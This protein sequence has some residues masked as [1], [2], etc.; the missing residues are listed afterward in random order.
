MPLGRAVVSVASIFLGVSAAW[1]QQSQVQLQSK[2]MP[3]PPL[4]QGIVVDAKGKTVGRLLNGVVVR[5]VNGTPV[6]IPVDSNGFQGGGLDNAVF[7]F[8]SADCTGTKYMDAGSILTTG[9]IITAPPSVPVPTL[10]FPAG[11]PTLRTI[12]SLTEGGPCVPVP[13]MA[14]MV[15]VTQSADVSSWG[16][17]PPF[18]VK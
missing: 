13:P 3:E 9:S 12:A 15:G 6:A 8:Q 2:T 10:F 18:K 17:V 14:S 16:L 4:V 7:L 5:L 11:T 1:A